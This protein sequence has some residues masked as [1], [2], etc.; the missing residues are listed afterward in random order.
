[1]LHPPP[2]PEI[3][4]DTRDSRILKRLFKCNIRNPRRPKRL[5]LLC[6]GQSG[7]WSTTL[8]KS[9]DASSSQLSPSH[10]NTSPNLSFSQGN[11]QT[12][13][14]RRGVPSPP[15][16]PLPPPPWPWSSHLQR[17]LCCTTTRRAGART[18]C[19]A[20]EGGQT[21][22]SKAVRGKLSSVHQPNLNAPFL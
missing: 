5:C 4:N 22:F 2:I 15:L 16:P 6:L 19:G 20:V 17:V 10:A 11:R 9:S 21:Q 18:C 1:M 3:E 13:D 8:C 7:L 14:H 12:I